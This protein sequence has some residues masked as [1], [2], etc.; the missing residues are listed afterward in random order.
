[1][2]NTLFSFLFVIFGIFFPQYINIGSIEGMRLIGF[3]YIVFTFI[4]IFFAIRAIKA[5]FRIA[6]YLLIL[7]NILVAIFYSVG[8]RFFLVYSLRT[9]FY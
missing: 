1:M 2:I 7:I 4:S 6:G 8:F 9:F 3:I 5:N